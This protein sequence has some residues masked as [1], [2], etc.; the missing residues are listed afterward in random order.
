[1]EM[2]VEESRRT[3]QDAVVFPMRRKMKRGQLWRGRP[4]DK[5]MEPILE[6]AKNLRLKSKLATEYIRWVVVEAREGLKE[7][8]RRGRGGGGVERG[9]VEQKT[10]ARELLGLF[11]RVE[12][13]VMDYM[14][15]L[16]ADISARHE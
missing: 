4:F 15:F 1:M 16:F 11:R 13:N 14:L 9:R 8:E 12:R 5:R 2:V 3:V 7:E 10:V 6:G